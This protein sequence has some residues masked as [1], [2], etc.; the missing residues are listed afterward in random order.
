MGILK[1]YESIGKGH[2]GTD[3]VCDRSHLLADSDCG[4]SDGAHMDSITN[5]THRG[6]YEYGSDSIV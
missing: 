5:I 2:L 6:Y 3:K 1:A 4:S